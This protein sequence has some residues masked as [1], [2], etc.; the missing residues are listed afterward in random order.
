[1]NTIKKSSM[2]FKNMMVYEFENKEEFDFSIARIESGLQDNKFLGCPSIMPA[3]QGWVAPISTT[4]DSPLVHSANGFLLICLCIERK[5]I[6]SSVVLDKLNEKVSTLEIGLGYKI[7]GKERLSLKDE[8]YADL[9]PRAFTKKEF[10]KVLIHPKTGL[11]V[12][13]SSS[14]TKAVDLIMHLRK[15]LGSLPVQPVETVHVSNIMT[16]WLRLE[17]APSPFDLNDNC[18]LLDRDVNNA[19]A[20]YSNHN[21]LSDSIQSSLNDGMQVIDLEL[22]WKEHVK[23]TLRND[24]SIVKIKFTDAIHDLASD[25]DSDDDAQELDSIFYIMSDT[26]LEMLKDLMIEFKR[27]GL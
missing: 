27:A 10:I 19:T 5:I 21:L 12:V 15:S 22:K 16:K 13:D 8:V 1:M 14:E 3:H 25:I 17:K 18:T 23:F 6:P 9:L 2:W 20:K 11:L 7:S 26:I 4:E 24:F